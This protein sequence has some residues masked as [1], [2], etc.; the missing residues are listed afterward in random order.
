MS[1]IP[2]V[3]TLVFVGGDAV[4]FRFQVQDLDA[5]NPENP[6]VTRDLTGYTARAQVR[7]SATSETIVATWT[8]TTPLGSDGIVRMYLSGEE[9]Q[10]MAAIKQLVSDVELTDPNGDPETMLS[11]VLQVSQDVTR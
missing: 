8:I 3:H 7:Q 11:L 10:P 2:P 1:G 9:T 4:H 6:P 5:D